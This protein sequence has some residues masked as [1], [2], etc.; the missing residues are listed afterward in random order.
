M[1]YFVVNYIYDTRSLFFEYEI[2]RKFNL[3]DNN[4]LN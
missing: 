4:L 1:N 2:N 3:N